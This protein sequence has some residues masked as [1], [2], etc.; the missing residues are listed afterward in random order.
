MPCQVYHVRALSRQLI[1]EGPMVSMTDF[2][3]KQAKKVA[4][5]Y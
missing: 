3:A 5:S 4:V 1:E 2:R